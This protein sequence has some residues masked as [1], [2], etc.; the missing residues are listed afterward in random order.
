MLFAFFTH[1]SVQH[2][3]MMFLSFNQKDRQYNGKKNK[4]KRTHCN[5]QNKTEKGTN[6][7]LLKVQIEQNEPTMVKRK[8][9]KEQTMVYKALHRKIKI[10]QHKLH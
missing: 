1:T 2:D 7:D 8:G 5:G 9:T 4:D 6:N 10:E 3:Q